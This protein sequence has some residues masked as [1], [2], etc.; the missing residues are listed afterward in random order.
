[1]VIMACMVNLSARRLQD[2]RDMKQLWMLYLCTSTLSITI[3]LEYEYI[4]IV[5][6]FPRNAL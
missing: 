4:G 5:M 3:N 6:T 2:T 1:M